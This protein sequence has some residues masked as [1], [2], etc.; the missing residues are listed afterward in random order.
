M[1]PALNR[2]KVQ[3]DLAV[4]VAEEMTVNDLTVRKQRTAL[5]EEGAERAVGGGNADALLRGVNH[6]IGVAL[7]DDLGRPETALRRAVFLHGVAARL[8][9][10]KVGRGVDDVAVCAVVGGI[11]VVDA[12]V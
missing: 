5:V 10:D 1:R 2:N 11:E 9:V 3:I 6:V 4:I 8:P 7:A 12:V